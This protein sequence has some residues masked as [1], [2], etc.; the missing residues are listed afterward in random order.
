[1]CFTTCDVT[2]YS[3]YGATSCSVCPRDTAC[4]DPLCDQLVICGCN[5]GY[6]F[7]W[8]TERTWFECRSCDVNI[9]SACGGHRCDRTGHCECNTGYTDEYGLTCSECTGGE[10]KSETGW[11][12]WLSCPA[13][14]VSEAGS[15]L[16]VCVSGHTDVDGDPC[17]ACGTRTYKNATGNVECSVCPAGT[18]E[19]TTG[20]VSYVSCPENS[21]VLNKQLTELTELT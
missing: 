15:V 11:S 18:Y 8:N 14:L 10:Y 4:V 13:G 6:W 1:M 2:T 7:Q 20:S 16:C 21:S 17:T 12:S 19:N 9:G 3:S 5:S